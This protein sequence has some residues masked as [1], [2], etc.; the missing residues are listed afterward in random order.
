MTPRPDG[1]HLPHPSHP[2]L[3]HISPLQAQGHQSGPGSRYSLASLSAGDNSSDAGDLRPPS[4]GPALHCCFHHLRCCPP[5]GCSLYLSRSGL[6]VNPSLRRKV[7][8]A[9]RR[10]NIYD[11]WH[12]LTCLSVFFTS[13]DLSNKDRQRANWSAWQEFLSVNH[14]VS[15]LLTCL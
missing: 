6:L 14:T 10:L 1:E 7:R 12:I 8:K 15:M 3:I 9:S 11:H 13:E 2:S 4:C 5:P